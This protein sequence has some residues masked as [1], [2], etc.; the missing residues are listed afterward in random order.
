MSKY[1]KGYTLTERW[2]TLKKH[3]VSS[4]GSLISAVEELSNKPND[5]NIKIVVELE[6]LLSDD[7]AKLDNEDKFVL[8]DMI[9]RIMYQTLNKMKDDFTRWDFTLLRAED[10]GVYDIF[11]GLNNLIMKSEESMRNYSS[12]GGSNNKYIEQQQQFLD[13]IN[14]LWEQFDIDYKDNMSDFYYKFFKRQLDR[15]IEVIQRHIKQFDDNTFGEWL[16]SI[17]LQK[18]WSLARASEETG[19]SSSYLHRIE[20]GNRSVPSVTKLEEIAKGYGISAT[21]MIT[22]ASGDIQSVDNYIAKGA[23]T[24]HGKLATKVQK[25]Q[26]GELMQLISENELEDAIQQLELVMKTINN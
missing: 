11:E 20:K 25:N 4:V 18:G 19:A 23:F 9:V 17:R 10:K 2:E 16:K 14:K 21:R 5:K 22:M 26:L 3:D 8:E 24:I 7:I 6:K 12:S 1:L 15:K 13:E